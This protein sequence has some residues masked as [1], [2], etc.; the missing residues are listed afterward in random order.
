MARYYYDKHKVWNMAVSCSVAYGHNRTE[1]WEVSETAY[2]DLTTEINNDIC[3]IRLARDT[4]IGTPASPSKIVTD[5]GKAYQTRLPEI[6]DGVHQPQKW[7]ILDRFN[8][9]L[10]TYIRREIIVSTNRQNVM[11]DYVETITAEEGAYP[12]NGRHSDGFWY[13]KKEI[14]N[15]APTLTLNTP[16][17][18]TLYENDT[19]PISGTAKETDVGDVVSVWY[20]IGN[21][22]PR[23]IDSRV[24]DGS[25]VLDYSAHLTFKAGK[26]QTANGTAITGALVASTSYK[27]RVWAEDNKGNKSDIIERTFYV[28]PNRPPNLTIDPF[29]QITGLIKNDELDFSGTANDPD[30]NDLKVAYRI[31]GSAPVEVYSGKSGAWSFK[32]SAS[33]LKDGENT[34]VVEVV[35]AYNVKVS[36]TLKLNK[37]VNRTPV[38]PSVLRYQIITAESAKSVRF[39]IRRDPEQE[40]SAEISMTNGDEPEQFVS[41]TLNK[42]TLSDDGSF[43]EDEFSFTADEDKEKIILKLMLA[44]DKPVSSVSGV[45]N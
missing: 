1:D 12:E 32:L 18:T 10:K 25:T 24:S 23:A 19:F 17:N 13:V 8:T 28:V 45:L 3:G 43:T 4:P 11:G 6:V 34:L 41:M 16:N 44:N 42:S 36:K 40:L 5:Q 30:D 20:Q 21:G 2:W 39:R 31:N 22:T 27:L 7:Y 26:L 35:D 33:K 29:A 15:S 9:N 37:M 14:A 38:A